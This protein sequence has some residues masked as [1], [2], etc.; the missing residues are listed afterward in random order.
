MLVCL[1]RGFAERARPH[2][3]GDV[4]WATFCLPRST[5]SEQAGDDRIWQARVS[6]SSGWPLATVN[7]LLDDLLFHLG[8]PLAIVLWLLLARC[9]YACCRVNN[10]NASVQNAQHGGLLP[11]SQPEG[12]ER[13]SPREPARAA[14][15]SGGVAARSRKPRAPSSQQAIERRDV[16]ADHSAARALV[17]RCLSG[18][19]ANFTGGLDALGPEAAGGCGPGRSRCGWG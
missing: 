19:A 11:S 8:R 15:R 17:L 6:T 16:V 5:A 2:R 10:A 7:L 1:D 4:F 13:C 14:S 3:K 12:M 18:V 9:D